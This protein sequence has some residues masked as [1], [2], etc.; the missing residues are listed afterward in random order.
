M[1]TPKKGFWFEPIEPELQNSEFIAVESKGFLAEASARFLRNKRA[2]FGLAILVFFAA[3]AL[4]GPFLVPYSYD[5]QSPAFV[6]APPSAAHWLGADKFGR[7]LFVRLCYGARIS[8]FIGFASALINLVIGCV[9]GGISG[10]AGGK[11][12]L[13][14]MRAVDIIYAVPSMLYVILIMMALGA[15]TK[16]IL[17]GICIPGWIGMARQVRGQIISLKQQEFSMAA[18]V[19]GAGDGRILFKHLMINAIGPIIVQLTFLVPQAI[20][21]EAFLSFVGV[22]ISAPL[23]SWGSMCQSAREFI[24]LYPLQMLWPTLSISLTIFSLNFLGEGI[25]DALNPRSK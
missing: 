11:V 9:L 12:D 4:F 8:L 23:A 3:L 1:E 13:I 2:V 20:F 17:I 21:T 19:L 24:T 22:G 7:D 14:I 25:G 15:N 10:Y 6:N 16:S 5:G 18:L